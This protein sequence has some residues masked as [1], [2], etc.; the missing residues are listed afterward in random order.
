MIVMTVVVMVVV[1]I[2]HAL[3]VVLLELM[4]C[5]IAV[6]T[7]HIVCDAGGTYH[8]IVSVVDSIFVRYFVKLSMSHLF[9]ITFFLYAS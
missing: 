1:V 3:I 9:S 2:V 8:S 6:A 5:A 7:C 4:I